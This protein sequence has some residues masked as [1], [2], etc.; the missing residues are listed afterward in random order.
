MLKIIKGTPIENQKNSFLNLAV[1]SLMMGEPGPPEKF[2]LTEELSVNLWDRWEYRQATPKTTLIDVIR[3]VDKLHD[4][5]LEF[6]DVFQAAKPLFIY[7]LGLTNMK[8]QKLS[9]IEECPEL[10]KSILELTG[11]SPKE[12]EIQKFMDLTITFTV[13]K[14]EGT[15]TKEGE[16]EILK[17]VPDIRVYFTPEISSS[18][19]NN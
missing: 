2:K 18:Q 11:T 15:D 12:I 13:K 10:N 7:S 16:Y 8:L 1:P 5:K 17:N 4:K 3:H 14:S 19:Q 6:R 9:K